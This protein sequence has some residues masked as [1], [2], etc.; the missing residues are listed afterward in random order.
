[1][2]RKAVA[3]ANIKK[4]VTP[5]VLRHCFAT[6]LLECGA[7]VTVVQMLLGHRSLRT[8]EKYTHISTAH[9]A[10]TGS[11][12]DVLGTPGSQILG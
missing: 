6:H 12:L 8:T 7:D 1:M 4:D 9:I 2:F 3:D 11:P 10:R 5:H